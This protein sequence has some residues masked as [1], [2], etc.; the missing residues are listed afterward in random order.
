[1]LQECLERGRE[2]IL[3]ID[4]ERVLAACLDM[5]AAGDSPLAARVPGAGSERLP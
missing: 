3:R 4:V 5:L 2:C 1:M